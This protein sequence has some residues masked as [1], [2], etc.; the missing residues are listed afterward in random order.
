M[1]DQSIKPA[2][3]AETAAPPRPR[4]RPRR[5]LVPLAT[6]LLF[7]VAAAGFGG[8]WYL[9]HLAYVDET[10]ARVDAEIVALSSRVSGWVVG[11]RIT[12]GSQVAK[13]DVLVRVDDRQS[14]IKL[15]ELRRD[16]DGVLAERDRTAA[17]I[18]LVDASTSSR[19]ESKRSE[20]AAARALSQS[21]ALE[22]KYAEDEYKRADEL[23]KRGVIAT[24]ALDQARTA[25]LKAQQEQLRARA[26]ETSAEADLREAEA[27]RRQVAV[28]EAER[29]RLEQN[30]KAIEQQIAAQQLDIDDRSIRSPIDGVIS[31]TFV[32]AGEYVTPGQRIALLHDPNE[33][34]VEA[35]IK[36]T[37][38]R[39]VHVG[40]PATVSVDAYPGE[41]FQG[42]VERT[43]HAATSEF[44]LLP[45]PNP[46]GNFTKVTQRIPV[47]I[48]LQQ[49][50][51]LLKPG[52]MV[53]VSID[54]GTD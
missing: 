16:R 9:H 47:R 6:L 39:R 1:N 24:R 21:L 15:D 20:L 5:F 53:E 45:T 2:R 42:V 52:M 7:V 25:F 10:D 27:A 13:N 44:S 12:E 34:W 3:D 22:L 46:S 37:E 48:T 51:G 23:S 33:I 36:E 14:Q 35:L 41:V 8:Q 18:A 29:L 19:E 11:M 4:R 54:V 43:G 26:Q 32:A 38:I 30:A 50:D 28:L 17:Q 49:R 31:R 40:Q